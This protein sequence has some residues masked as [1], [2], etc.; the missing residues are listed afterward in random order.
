MLIEERIMK[1]IVRW[2]IQC[3]LHQPSVLRYSISWFAAPPRHMD[4]QQH[5]WYIFYSFAR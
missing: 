5:S 1:K 4:D 2:F 3:N